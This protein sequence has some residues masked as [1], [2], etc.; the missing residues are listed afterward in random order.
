MSQVIQTPEQHYYLSKL[1]EFDYT[2]QY[3][4]GASNVVADALS[5]TTLCSSGQLLLL[6]VPNFNFL[7][8]LRCTLHASPNFL[9]IAS[10]MSCYYFEGIFG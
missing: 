3:K 10:T 6:S 8:D 5:R 1:L 7:D 9:T 4:S 2:I